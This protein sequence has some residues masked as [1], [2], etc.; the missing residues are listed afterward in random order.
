[1]SDTEKKSYQNSDG[2]GEQVAAHELTK[3]DSNDNDTPLLVK[4]TQAGIWKVEAA[5]NVWGPVSK[6][7]LWLGIGLASYMY[8]LDNNT[9]WEFGTYATNEFGHANWYSAIQC[10]MAILLALGKPF[11][12]KI[13]DVIGRAEA[14]AVCL[15]FYCLGYIICASAQTMGALGAGLVIYEIGFSG[16]Q[17]AIQIVIADLTPLRY[18]ALVSALTSVPYFINFYAGA[19]IEVQIVTSTRL[20]WRWGYGLYCICFVFAI[21]P[22]I[23]VLFWAQNRAK[24]ENLVYRDSLAGSTFLEKAWSFVI[25]ADLVGMFFLGATITLVFLPLVLAGGSYATTTWTDPAIPAMMVIGGVVAA[26]AFIYWELKRAKFPIVPFRLLRNRTVL[27]ACIVNFF[28]FVSFYLTWSYLYTFT[29]VATDWDLTNLNYYSTAQSLCLTFFGLLWGAIVALVGGRMGYKWSFVAGLALRIIGVGLMFYARSHFSTAALVMTQVIQGAG[30]GIAAVASQVGAQGAVPHQDVAVA[31]AA[32]LLFAEVGGVVGQ[33]AA[34]SMWNNVL[35]KKLE[36]QG[37]NSTVIADVLG[38]Y[39]YARTY[40][41]DVRSKIITAYSQAMHDMLI[42][43]IVLACVAFL[44][45][46][47][48]KN[49]NLTGAQN[50]VE[51][52]DIRGHTIEGEESIEPELK[53]D[54]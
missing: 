35:P 51:V 17:I 50:A 6:T 32:V 38:S 47:A 16:L 46:F 40:P 27:V 29:Y 28:D 20:G 15:F 23:A 25:E 30:G 43:A 34:G 22:I 8:G 5:V 13:T 9:S 31:T 1:M 14:Y 18:R 54:V 21:G 41:T 45:S 52:K 12:A 48:C 53:R 39:T 24:K 37:L 44:V 3:Y 7:L 33:A 11:F 26:P 4:Q 19:Q 10:A 49:F 2:A 36:Q 42:P